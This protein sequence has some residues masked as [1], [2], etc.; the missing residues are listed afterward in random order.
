MSR[1]P[2]V[3]IERA[4]AEPVLEAVPPRP[5]AQFKLARAVK[6]LRALIADPDKTEN[7]VDV[8]YA[9]GTGD[10]ERAFR[11]FVALPGGRRLLAQRTSL[12]ALLRDRAAL[13]QLPEESL[14]RAYLTY[15]ERTGFVAD[16]LVAVEERVSA[17]WE[18][19]EGVPRLDPARA[20]FRERSLLI[21]DL[22]HVLTGYGTDEIGEATLLA[23]DWAQS[24][25]FSNGLLTFGA[26]VEGCRHLG[27]DWVRYAAHAWRRGRRARWLATLPFEALLPLSLETVRSIAALDP[28]ACAHPEGVFRG[29]LA[30]AA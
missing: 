12:L 1:K 11:R 23:F 28:L 15:L 22:S 26:W 16:G 24:P 17:R 5:P 7:A 25:G 30:P 20:W 3:V 14:G 4:P 9:V 6:T 2:I 21:H 10:F 27:M 29:T 13:E 8:I 19:E 18:A